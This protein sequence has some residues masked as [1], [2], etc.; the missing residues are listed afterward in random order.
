MKNWKEVERI[1]KVKD[2]LAKEIETLAA[3]LIAKTKEL[4]M[5]NVEQFKAAPEC[6]TLLDSSP[7]SNTRVMNDFKIHL[8]KNGCPWERKY[9]TDDTQTFAETIRLGNK[10]ALK[11]RPKNHKEETKE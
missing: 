7:I 11:M 5:L 10:W 2:A 8:L 1:A 6:D 3:A 9:D 4:T